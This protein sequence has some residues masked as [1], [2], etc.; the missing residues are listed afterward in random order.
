MII[1]D[2]CLSSGRKTAVNTCA[3]SR[4]GG[5]IAAALYDGSIQIWKNNPPFV[6]YNHASFLFINTIATVTL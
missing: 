4:D 3:Y 2:Y 6:S 5:L 1:H